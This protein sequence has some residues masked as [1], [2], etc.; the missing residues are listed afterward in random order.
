MLGGR[1][2]FIEKYLE[3][4]DDLN[5]RGFDVLSFDW[6]GQG[7]SQRLLRNTAKGHVACYDDYVTDLKQVL[8]KVLCASCP[9]PLYL[10]AHS[11]GAHIALHYLRQ[12]E[13]GISRAVLVAPMVDINTAP[14]PPFALRTLSRWMLGIGW[15]QLVLPGPHHNDVFN[16]SFEHNRLT[17]DPVRFKRAKQVLREQ[18]QLAVAGVTFGW[19][20]ATFD[21]ID[22]LHSPGYL[23]SVKIPMLVFVAGRDRIVSNT[24]THRLVRRM[25]NCKIVV[26]EEARHEI[27][28][29][30]DSLRSQ[31][32]LAFDDFVKACRP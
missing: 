31:F 5:G 30:L 23:D 9:K 12:N 1:A 22:M 15:Q 25:P 26:I 10:L 19:L 32:W 14:M 28:Q 17:S 29:E 4:I 21:S 18:P 13:H 24:A 27:L 20:A 8:D 6:R 7:G 3:T 11:M 2:E 16:K